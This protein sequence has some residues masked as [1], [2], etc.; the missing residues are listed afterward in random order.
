MVDP[1]DL[2]LGADGAPIVR[3]RGDEHTG[4]RSVPIRFT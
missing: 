2:D 4:F 3:T 1:T